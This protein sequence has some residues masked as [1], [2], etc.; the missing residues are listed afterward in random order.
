[1]CSADIIR[2]VIGFTPQTQIWVVN[3]FSSTLVKVNLSN[4]PRKILYNTIFHFASSHKLNFPDFAPKFNL[5][6]IFDMTMGL[7]TSAA[8]L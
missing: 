2:V 8:A 4:V 5:L 1:M 3:F 6:V 7:P